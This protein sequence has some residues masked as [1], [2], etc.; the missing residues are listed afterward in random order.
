[1]VARRAARV[2]A[3][4]TPGTSTLPKRSPH[5]GAPTRLRQ[6]DWLGSGSTLHARP[7]DIGIGLEDCCDWM[8]GCSLCSTYSQNVNKGA[9]LAFLC[10]AVPTAPMPFELASCI[11]NSLAHKNADTLR[12]PPTRSNASQGWIAP[13]YSPRTSVSNQ[14]SHR[15]LH[16]P[17]SSY[18][19]GVRDHI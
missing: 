3:R 11:W 1:M 5:H 8:P 13:K 14:L 6:E 4:P 10:S 15:A 7:L 16:P 12:R 18:W 17:G 19:L 9:C 2:L